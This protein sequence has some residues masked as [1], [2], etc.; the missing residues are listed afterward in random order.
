MFPLV[1]PRGA[2][3]RPK[4]IHVP[5]KQKWAHI[6]PE[7]LAVISENSSRHGTSYMWMDPKMK[8]GE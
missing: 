1:Q 8:K 3:V 5:K 4:A 6:L 2:V 7:K